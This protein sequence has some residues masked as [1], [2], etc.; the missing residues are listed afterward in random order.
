MTHL[1]GSQKLPDV[2]YAKKNKAEGL[3][4][5][6]ISADHR[7]FLPL[8]LSDVYHIYHCKTSRDLFS[9]GTLYNNYL[10]RLRVVIGS[11]IDFETKVLGM[12]LI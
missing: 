5:F 12:I 8:K 9:A 2:R 4:F 7:V 10:D 1:R 11:S 6:S 3:I